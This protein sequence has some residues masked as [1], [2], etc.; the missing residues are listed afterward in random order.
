[1]SEVLEDDFVA[2]ARSAYANQVAAECKVGLDRVVVLPS[3]VLSL[4]W[5]EKSCGL[6]E[7][8]FPQRDCIVLGMMGRDGPDQQTILAA[9]ETSS[10]L[11]GMP[12]VVLNGEEYRQPS[13][14]DFYQRLLALG[15]TFVELSYGGQHGITQIELLQL[16]RRA[17]L[18]ITG[19][20]GTTLPMA[21]FEDCAPTLWW[22]TAAPPFSI[23]PELYAVAKRYNVDI[24]NSQGSVGVDRL[25]EVME[26]LLLDWSLR[27]RF[28]DDCKATFSEH[29][30]DQSLRYFRDM[31]RRFV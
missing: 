12:F 16:M 21:L 29:L 4:A 10:V 23:Y 18:L 19:N 22:H 6:P 20:S 30:P 1:M 9:I 11:R 8:A 25:R 24:D 2:V 28:V 14:H 26:R 15:A 17:V 31:E 27:K 5:W 3:P 7:T 13:K